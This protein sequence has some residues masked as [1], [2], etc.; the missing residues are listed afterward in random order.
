M[1]L[2]KKL[3]SEA[4]FGLFHAYEK[5]THQKAIQLRKEGF[6]VR[7]S[8][9]N[10]PF[11]RSHKIYWGQAVVECDDVSKLNPDDSIYTFPQK[12]WIISMQHQPKK[13]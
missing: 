8:F 9:E 3:I 6:N 11:P 7:D 13:A 5:I 2:K 10:K 4:T 1:N 12:L